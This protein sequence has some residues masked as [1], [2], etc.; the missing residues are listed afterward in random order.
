MTEVL[1]RLCCASPRSPHCRQLRIGQ[2]TLAELG[3]PKLFQQAW[4]LI[5]KLVEAEVLAAIDGRVV[6]VHPEV[7][8]RE[9]AG[10]PLAWSKRSWNG[11]LLRRDLLAGAG[12]ALPD[13]IS[14]V[15]G[16]AADDVVDAAAAAWSARRLAKG[17][18]RSLPD[19]PQLS[20]GRRVAIWY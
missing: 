3:A 4:A 15:T 11:L 20:D 12:I 6:E 18:G 14:G 8:F 19:P 2:R 17:A 10:R 7:S 13:L 16:A 9:L 5:P 1:K